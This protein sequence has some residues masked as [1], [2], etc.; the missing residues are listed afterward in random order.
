M[1]ILTELLWNTMSESDTRWRKCRHRLP[2]LSQTSRASSVQLTWWSFGVFSDRVNNTRIAL[3]ST[4]PAAAQM[5]KAA[6]AQVRTTV[7][8][9]SG[10]KST[11]LKARCS[12]MHWTTRSIFMSAGPQNVTVH[13]SMRFILLS[14]VDTRGMTV[15]VAF[16][17]HVISYSIWRNCS[18]SYRFIRTQ[19][20]T[21]L[22]KSR[23]KCSDIDQR[24]CCDIFYGT[25]LVIFDWLVLSTF[26]WNSL[27][28]LTAFDGLVLVALEKRYT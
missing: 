5:W 11:P 14:W 2:L 15:I 18:D 20:G 19:D 28:I 27:S 25:T 1:S 9:S 13:V 16:N 24:N 10:S 12:R 17:F 3:Q 22:S 8:L 26:D 6:A 4:S 21:V 23:W 7:L